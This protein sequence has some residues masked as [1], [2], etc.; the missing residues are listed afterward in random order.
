MQGLAHITSSDSR[1]TQHADS[2]FRRRILCTLSHF[3]LPAS[4]TR[5][6]LIGWAAASAPGWLAGSP[7][8]GRR[9]Y[10][11][12]PVYRRASLCSAVAV[13]RG[14]VCSAKAEKR[15]RDAVRYVGTGRAS[16]GWPGRQFL[17]RCVPPWGL[18]PGSSDAARA[19]RL[20]RRLY[21]ARS[22]K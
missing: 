3:H 19:R 13:P 5:S 17:R 6:P 4:S 11:P 18:A 1:V 8:G 12:R 7:G 15:Q 2:R 20:W 16:G 10:L 14:R 21:K 9:W 22:G